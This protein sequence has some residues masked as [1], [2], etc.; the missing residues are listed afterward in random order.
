MNPRALALVSLMAAAPA[1]AATGAISDAAAAVSAGDLQKAKEFFGA[2]QK[3]Y[4]T[5]E[6][7]KALNKFEEAYAVRPHPA[8]SYNIG[9]CYEQL[10]E[11]GKAMR[12]FRDY[13]RMQPEAKDKESVLDAIANL[14]RRLKERGVQQML[15]FAD[16]PAAKIEIDGKD[17]GVQP[18]STELTAGQHKIVVRAAGFES[19]ERRFTMSI[20]RAAEMT[21]NLPPGSTPGIPSS[22]LEVKPK[23]DAPKN[24]APDPVATLTPSSSTTASKLALETT[25]EVTQSAPKRGRVFTWVAGGLAVGAAGGGVGLGLVSNSANIDLHKQVHSHTDAQALNDRASQFATGANI[26]Y[27]VAAGLAITAVVLFFVEK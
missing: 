6:Y 14:E 4:K 17:L 20:S 26:A 12:A 5:G 3:L 8:I 15:V 10:G 11:N 9:K 2:G 16:P 13:L 27:G 1:S 19:V 7:T 24:D 22:E 25:P 21:I 23:P 18:A